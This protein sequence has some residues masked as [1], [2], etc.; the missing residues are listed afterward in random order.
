MLIFF[1]IS[2]FFLYVFPSNR[3]FW[4]LNSVPCPQNKK[5]NL[6]KTVLRVAVVIPAITDVGWHETQAKG[7][8]NI[9]CTSA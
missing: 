5:Q 1:F 8:E 3:N 7:K 2:S 9:K 6:S 4:F